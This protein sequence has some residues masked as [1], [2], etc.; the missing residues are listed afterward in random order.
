MPLGTGSYGH[1][2]RDNIYH[3]VVIPKRFGMSAASFAWVTWPRSRGH[4][5]RSKIQLLQRLSPLLSVHTARRWH[6]LENGCR[7]GG[8]ELGPGAKRFAH[9]L[10]FEPPL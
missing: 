8:N 1:M 3:L 4:R 9:T 10:P 5:A 7:N 6:E 2:L